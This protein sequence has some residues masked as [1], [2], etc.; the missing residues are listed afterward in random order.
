MDAGIQ[1]SVQLGW[2]LQNAWLI[3]LLPFAAFLINGIFL[4]KFHKAAAAV[5]VGAMGLAAVFALGMCLQFFSG[6]FSQPV[7]AI[8]WEFLRFSAGLF[9]EMGVMLDRISVM[10]ATVVA[11]VSF[12]IHVYSI[13]YMHG[14]TGFPRF[15]ACLSLFT[16][17]MLGLVFANNIFQIYVFWE[18]VGVSSFLLIG[19]YYYKPS[20][21]AASKKA[22][23]VT[24]FADLGFLLGV[25]IVSYYT[26]TFDFAQLQ[27]EAA[28][29]MLASKSFM[30][31]SL[32][33]LAAV[34]I[35][36]GAA[37]K[38]AMFP[39]HIWLPDAMEGPTP[40]SAL[41]H[42]ATMVVAGVYL[43]ARLFG[44]FSASGAGL[45]VVMYVGTFTCLFAAL[46]AFT[47]HD[48]KRVLAFFT[49]SQLGYMMLALGV[50]TG[51]SA[52]G[53]TASMFHMTTHAFFKS[54]LFLAV[55]SVIHA[56]HTNDIWEMGGLRKKMPLTHLTFLIATLAIAG[57]PPLAGFFSKDEILVAAL[58][59]GHTF[60]FGVAMLVA[61]MTAFYMFRIY[62]VT[63]WGRPYEKDI[64]R[65]EHAHESPLVMTVPLL[66]LAT[67]SVLAGF[68]PFGHHV[69]YGAP[70]EHHGINWGVAVPATIVAFIGIAA[71]FALYS[72]RGTTAARIANSLGQ[73]YRL[74]LHKFY[75]DELYLFV[76]K[77]IIFRFI[78]EPLHWFDRKIVDGTMDRIGDITIG[79][80]RILRKTVTGKVQTYAITVTG[81]FL[82]LLFALW[83]YSRVVG[84]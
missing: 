35:Y 66:V 10:L 78:S 46:I 13:G 70:I 6:E 4:Q 21:V 18:L 11:V 17:S 71:A 80:G 67:L 69:Y 51:E 27:S 40:V 36:C 30:G 61:G 62:F 58:E 54:L 65:Y 59:N 1:T 41:I 14:D 33:T 47:Q 60:V 9:A 31:I 75:I 52:L 3:P 16:F 49:L 68:L 44:L 45:E 20:A 8:R 15:F 63:F 42:A 23:I 81:G 12:L 7:M 56:V 74:V 43:V 28:I 82:V 83:H 19:F 32:L 24:R 57:V 72:K 77:K 26:G 76:T 73:A 29:G 55:G 79:A 39:L 38:S 53:F 2:F 22:F 25:L 50:S 48:I 84:G 37:G 5:S 64:K 34:L